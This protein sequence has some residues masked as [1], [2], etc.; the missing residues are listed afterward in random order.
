MVK[1]DQQMMEDKL[2]NPRVT[3]PVEI[4][5]RTMRQWTHV[6]KVYYAH[7]KDDHWLLQREI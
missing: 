6:D 3:F 2:E 4:F 7:G 1:T 5:S